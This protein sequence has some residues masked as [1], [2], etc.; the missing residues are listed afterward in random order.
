MPVAADVDRRTRTCQIRS[1]SSRR[2]LR[3]KRPLVFANGSLEFSL[4]RGWCPRASRGGTEAARTPDASRRSVPVATCAGG[5][6]ADFQSAVSRICYPRTCAKA[7]GCGRLTG[8]PNAIRRYSR[9]QVCATSVATL[10]RCDYEVRRRKAGFSA[11]ARADWTIGG[12]NRRFRG[13]PTL[14][15]DTVP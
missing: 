4:N 5:R 7:G 15:R 10:P 12:N 6:S 1:A 2:R 8:L 14:H 3:L 9:L 13:E 11:S